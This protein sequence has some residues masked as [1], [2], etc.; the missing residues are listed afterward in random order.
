M[1][2]IVILH[3]PGCAKSRATLEL[4][5]GRGLNPRVVEYL[6]N[7]PDSAELGR[8]LDMLGM[9]PRELMRRDEAEYAALDLQDERLDHAHLLAAM[10]A[11]PRL[12][13]RP[14]VI[15]NGRAALGRP[16]ETVLEIL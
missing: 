12:I 8:I 7:P 1:S 3:N 9:S 15:A 2:E 16:P 4:L 14:I 11:H 10:C 13:Q 6:D 5:T